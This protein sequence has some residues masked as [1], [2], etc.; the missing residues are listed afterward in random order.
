MC[1]GGRETRRTLLQ[2]DALYRLH[3][4]Q[5]LNCSLPVAIRKERDSKA[6]RHEISILASQG[7]IRLFVYLFFSFFFVYLKKN[8]CG[9]SLV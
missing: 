5:H 6:N 9:F 2:S 1:A 3:S 7:F 4:L 8:Q